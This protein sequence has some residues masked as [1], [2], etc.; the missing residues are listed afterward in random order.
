MT[1]AGPAPGGAHPVRVV[2]YVNQFFAGLGGEDAA[3]APPQ[4][5]PGPVGP[6]RRLQALLGA[7]HE[8]VA[9]VSCGDDYAATRP[10][11]SRRSSSW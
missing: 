1:A 3:G 7:E 11:P 2:H 8:I 9:T 10:V 5:T 4:V 6:G